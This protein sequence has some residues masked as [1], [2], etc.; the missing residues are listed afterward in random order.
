MGWRFRRSVKI[1]PGIRW[2]IG[3]RG[4][5]FSF[6]GRG[7]TV[8][9]SSR[10]VRR[11]ISIPGTGLSHTQVVGQSQ[12]NVDPPPSSGYPPPLTGASRAPFTV[13]ITELLPFSDETVARAARRW[14]VAH[15]NLVGRALKPRV[16]RRSDVHRTAITYSV[17]SKEVI[18]RTEPIARKTAPEITFPEGDDL[19]P[20]S[21]DIAEQLPPRRLVASCRHC[22]GDGRRTCEQCVGRVRVTC[23][24]CSGSGEQWSPRSG[25][26]I[27]CSECK[28]KGAAA[29]SVS[30]RTC[31]LRH[32]RRQRRCPSVVGSGGEE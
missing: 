17:R 7:F 6:G 15:Y 18:A 24:A 21:P 13:P 20:W 16:V 14:A 32:V 26:T 23:A 2:N 8:N 19:D 9:I 3:T 10:G 27:R 11:T 22:Q 29:L 4:S 28:G 5:S 30:R 1:A 31:R 12:R 25:R